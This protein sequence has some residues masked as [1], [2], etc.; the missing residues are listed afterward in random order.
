MSGMQSFRGY[1]LMVENGR[2]VYQM[3]KSRSWMPFNSFGTSNAFTYE[4]IS[5]NGNTILVTYIINRES[6]GQHTRV[7]DQYELSINPSSE[8]LSAKFVKNVRHEE[9]KEENPVEVKTE[10]KKQNTEDKINSKATQQVIVNEPEPEKT[11][12]CAYCGTEG[13][14]KSM[15]PFFGRYFHKHCWSEYEDT[16]EGEKDI[17]DT[18]AY[19]K[20]LAE[21]R[22][23]E[24]KRLRNE[25]N[26]AW[27]TNN[28]FGKQIAAQCS[29]S[30]VE[31]REEFIENEREKYYQKLKVIKEK[32]HFCESK[33]KKNCS[34]FFPKNICEK[35]V[36]VLADNC[37][38]CI[39]GDNLHSCINQQKV[40]ETEFEKIPQKHKVRHAIRIYVDIVVALILGGA[41]VGYIGENNI[42]N[43][44]IFFLIALLFIGSPIL[45]HFITKKQTEN[46]AAKNIGK[47]K[48]ILGED[49]VI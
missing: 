4:D 15:E 37:T 6:S 8:W 1:S 16:E 46:I 11:R 17:A 19:Y 45:G 39:T 26:L 49:F 14:E 12:M 25:A 29:L 18:R 30:D 9:I 32:L 36:K 38:K 35:I 31:E 44:I 5:V 42:K 33:F 3:P 2:V 48:E 13:L 10:E 23:K 34:N 24:R 7:T 43:A 20:E 41:G 47:I 22:E 21:K 28:E 40:Y 27:I